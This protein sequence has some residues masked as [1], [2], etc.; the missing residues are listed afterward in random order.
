[1]QVILLEKV[2]NFGALGEEV[3]V[4]PGFARNYLYPQGKAVPATKV[5]IEKFEARRADLEKAANEKLQAA[6][7][8]AEKLSDIS[9][10]ITAKAGD[11]GKLFGSIGIRDV[12]E[13]ITKAGLE[14]KKSEV[15]LANGAIRQIGDYEINIQLHGDVTAVVKVNVIAE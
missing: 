15:E 11:E 14:V 4:K 3:T 5:N 2:K 8:K 12:A 6:K 7:V 9:V 13:A 1:M 10:T